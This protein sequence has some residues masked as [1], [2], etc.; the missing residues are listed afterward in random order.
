M[1]GKPKAAGD[2]LQRALQD[3]ARGSLSPCY[4]IFGADEFLVRDA[5]EQLVAALLPPA[6]RD[7]NLFTLDGDEVDNPDSLCETL[8]TSPLLPGRKVVLVRGAT[9]FHSRQTAADLV[10]RVRDHLEGNPLRA[11]RDFITF[12]AVAG[13]KLDDLRD[14]GWKRISDDTWN[15]LVEGD[16]GQDRS[17]WLPRVVALCIEKGLNRK[18]AAGGDGEQLIRTLSGG[19]PE[20]HCLI[21]TAAGVDKRKR[22]FKA[23]SDVGVVIAFPDAKPQGRERQPLV[24]AS[25]SLLAASGKSLT[26]EAWTLLGEKTGFDIRNGMAALEKLIVYA[27]PRTEI[28]EGDVA[29]LVGK[30][31]EDTVFNLTNA[32]AEK[33]LPACLAI[34][35]ELLVR[36]TPPIMILAMIAREIRLLLQARLLILQGTL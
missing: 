11:G 28:D 1:K 6:D 31:R 10:R 22:L 33:D 18:E 7:L 29:A 9:F 19:L 30:T 36:G 12:L 23:I 16:A 25:R 3:L 32:L 21:V 27:G 14:D 5:Q 15:D 34:L 17:I 35:D 8:L 20:G 24:A 13:W 4:L 2:E 26:E